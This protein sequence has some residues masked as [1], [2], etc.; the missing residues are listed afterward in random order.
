MSVGKQAYRTAPHC[1]TRRRAGIDDASPRRID[2]SSYE[3]PLD[4]HKEEALNTRAFFTLLVV[5]ALSAV[6]LSG[7]AGSAV[8]LER[9]GE[10]PCD[11]VGTVFRDGNGDL[12][13]DDDRWG[14]AEPWSGDPEDPDEDGA[15]GGDDEGAQ[16][17][18]GLLKPEPVTPLFRLRLMLT[19][20]FALSTAR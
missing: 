3:D 4:Y 10:R 16:V 8:R 17:A 11:V 15:S 18:S 13:G 19:W 14:D 2:R 12:G 9:A 20:V 7:P 5:L 6:L 1:V